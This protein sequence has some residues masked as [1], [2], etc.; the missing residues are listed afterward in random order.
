MVLACAVY[1]I[2]PPTLG[3]VTGVWPKD[4]RPVVEVVEF[5]DMTPWEGAGRACAWIVR[6]ALT[7]SGLFEIAPIRAASPQQTVGVELTGGKV[8]NAQIGGGQPNAGV[9]VYFAFRPVPAQANH[10]RSRPD[11]RIE[12]VIAAFGDRTRVEAV[13]HRA[14]SPER[15]TG[16]E[17]LGS[18]TAEGKGQGKIPSLADEIALKALYLLTAQAASK[19]ID[20]SALS[21]LRQYRDGRLSYEIAARELGKLAEEFGHT[22]AI[23]AYLLGH[24]VSRP[25]R[26]Q[27]VRQQAQVVA[28]LYHANMPQV[29]RLLAKIAIDPFAIL[30]ECCA[31]AGDW[32]GAAHAHELAVRKRVPNASAHQKEQFLAHMKAGDIDAAEATIRLLSKNVPNDTDIFYFRGLLAQSKGDRK[33]AARMFKKHL[34]SAPSGE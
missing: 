29:D 24:L 10:A 25:T 28:D 7:K 21:I 1:V 30:A 18:V 11:F 19:Q 26:N 13:V 27:V 5:R 4:S 2:A 9:D 31:S 22:F 15:G 6:S 23:E 32:R 14:R 33:S 3:E 34:R 17:P 8:E 20:R 16:F 12:G